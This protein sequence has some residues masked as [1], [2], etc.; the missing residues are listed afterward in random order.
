MG[1]TVGSWNR[2]N[3]HESSIATI[4]PQHTSFSNILSG[5]S[6]SKSLCTQPIHKPSIYQEIPLF[7]PLNDPRH[8]LLFVQFLQSATSQNVGLCGWCPQPILHSTLGIGSLTTSSTPSRCVTATLYTS[9]CPPYRHPPWWSPQEFILHRNQRPSECTI[10]SGWN[11]R[12]YDPL[13]LRLIY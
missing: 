13:P 4:V 2:T 8:Q 3:E 12:R 7:P 11:L 5:I 10:W 9:L 1:S 6:L